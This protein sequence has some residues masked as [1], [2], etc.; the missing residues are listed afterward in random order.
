VSMADAQLVLELK[1]R[2]EVLEALIEGDPLIERVQRLEMRCGSLQS[3]INLLRNKTPVAA[4]NIIGDG[5][6]RTMGAADKADAA[7]R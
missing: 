2:I 6:T 5:L 4:T 1:R 7:A 3:Q